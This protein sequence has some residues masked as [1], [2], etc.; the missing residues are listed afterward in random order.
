MGEL[1]LN[2]GVGAVLAPV[3]AFAPEVAIPLAGMGVA[4]GVDEFRQGHYATGT[5]DVVTSV[6]GARGARSSPNWRAPLPTRVT[7]AKLMVARS[8][9]NQEEAFLHLRGRPAATRSSAAT[10]PARSEAFDSLARS[11]TTP[12]CPCGS[13]TR[14]RTRLQNDRSDSTRRPLTGTA[15]AATSSSAMPQAETRATS[16]FRSSRATSRHR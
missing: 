5:F 11:S 9:L 10:S 2:M 4:S 15:Y 1:F 7:N 13:T 3:V 16:T 6:L 14:S 8:Q 12:T